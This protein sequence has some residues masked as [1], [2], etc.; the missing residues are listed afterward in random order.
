MKEAEVS[1]SGNLVIYSLNIKAN[2]ALGLSLEFSD[3]ELSEN[4]VLSI[5]SRF[6]LTDSITNSENND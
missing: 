2:D 3:F 1:E 5:F 4:A 6:E